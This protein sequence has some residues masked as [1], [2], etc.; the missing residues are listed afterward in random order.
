MIY[1]STYI[2]GWGPPFKYLEQREENKVDPRCMSLPDVAL[3]HCQIQM[4]TNVVV[5]LSSPEEEDCVVAVKFFV[6]VDGPR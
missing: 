1:L 6:F 5:S 4:V 2:S 3:S